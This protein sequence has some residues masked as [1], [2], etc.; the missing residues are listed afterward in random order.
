MN[1]ARIHRHVRCGR[2]STL[3]AALFGACSTL[4]SLPAGA[5]Y[6]QQNLVSGLQRVRNTAVARGYNRSAGIAATRLH[7]LISNRPG[8]QCL[9]HHEPK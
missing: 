8:I 7:Q 3:I 5:G 9:Q 4:L 1:Y 6:I 2:H